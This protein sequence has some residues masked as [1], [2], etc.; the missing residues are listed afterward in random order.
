MTRNKSFIRKIIYLC[1]IAALFIPISLISAPATSRTEGGGQLTKMRREY[2]LSQAQLGKIDPASASMS[3]ATLGMRGVAANLLWGSAIHYKKTENW[4]AFMAALNQITKLQPNFVSVWQ[5]QSWNVS[6]NISVE[7]DDYRHRYH[8]VKKGIDYLTEGIEYNDEEP[9]L[10]SDAGWFFGHKIGRADEYQQFRRLFRD[11]EEFHGT[12]RE[13]KVPIDDLHGPD[14]KPDNWLVSNHWF[15]RAQRSVDRGAQL[16]RLSTHY[17]MGDKPVVDKKQTPLRGKNPLVFHSEAPKAL[18]R[19]ADA[20]EEDGYLEETGQFAWR[21]AERAWRAYG[22]RD[23]LSSWGITIHLNDLERAQREA[24]EAETRLQKLTPGVA[25][26]LRKEKLAMLTP[27]ERDVLEIPTATRSADQ[28]Q[29]AREVE[30]KIKVSS[31]EIASAAPE[32]VRQEASVLAV[33]IE[34]NREKARIVERYRGVVNFEY[35]LQRCI[36]EQEDNTIDARELV[37]EAE[38]KFDETDLNGARELFEKA[39]DHWAVVFQRYPIMID[40]VEGELVMESIARYQKLLGQLDQPFPPQDFKL[41]GLLEAYKDD[42]DFETVTGAINSS[43]APEDP[44]NEKRPADTDQ[45]EEGD[46]DPT[47][48]PPDAAVE[49]FSGDS[50]SANVPVPDEPP[51]PDAGF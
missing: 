3:L 4:D 39:W 47:A 46:L 42:F 24:D 8:W 43:A 13:A 37:L 34:T 12:L 20:I 33:T 31:I 36:C 29:L 18:I 14:E 38:Q 50:D 51:I 48:V 11:D 2:R 9:L 26:K 6:Y 28:R 10:L 17:W 15:R 25:E 41:L 30:G 7:F 1:G 27:T 23:I 49:P 45:A 21:D 5:Y 32:D 35:W 44:P 19:F 16:S 22:D 40:D